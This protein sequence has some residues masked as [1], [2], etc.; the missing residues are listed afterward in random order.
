M[1][2]RKRKAPK[3]ARIAEKT[4]APAPEQVALTPREMIE[5]AS[6]ELTRICE[7]NRRLKLSIPVDPEDSDIIFRA[8][9]CQASK[10]LTEVDILRQAMQ[11]ALASLDKMHTGYCLYCGHV[12]GHA[13]DCRAMQAT[14]IL[15][16]G[17][18]N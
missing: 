15:K 13:D 1:I 3:K 5:R 4:P 18:E 9:L 7:G 17:L 14:H 16:K 11:D 10:A 2:S 6:E 12:F 8:A